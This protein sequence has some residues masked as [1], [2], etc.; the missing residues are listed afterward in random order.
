MII[1]LYMWNKEN[2]YKLKQEVLLDQCCLHLVK[3][4]IVSPAGEGVYLYFVCKR[5]CWVMYYVTH[6]IVVL[7][8][9]CFIFLI[10]LWCYYVCS[11]TAGVPFLMT[12]ELFKQ[13]HRPSAYI[14]GGF[15]NWISNF[16]VGFVFPFLQVR[17]F[18]RELAVYCGQNAVHNVFIC[19]QCWE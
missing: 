11:C 19:K 3:W 17:L 4:S 9:K 2:S 10:W 13:S 6:H 12:G 16:T 1:F 18:F 14:V 5:R 8:F 15:L 7:L